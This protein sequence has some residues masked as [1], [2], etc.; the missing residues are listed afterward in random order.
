MCS[1]CT[2]M[3]VLVFTLT[4]SAQR[5]GGGMGGGRVAGP[6]NQSGA[7][8][9]RAGAPAPF[10]GNRGIYLS[11]QS[12]S[13]PIPCPLLWQGWCHSAPP[14]WRA[15]VFRAPYPRVVVWNGW[16]ALGGYGFNSVADSGYPV[17]PYWPDEYAQ[18]FNVP[19]A[20]PIPIDAPSAMSADMAPERVEKSASDNSALPVYQGPASQPDTSEDHPPLVALKNRWAYTV[21]KYWVQGKTFHFITTQG[22]HMQ[23]PVALVERVYPTT[24]RSHRIEPKPAPKN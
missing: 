5:H 10:G 21:L 17:E 22:D 18:S 19:V 11:W 1:S 15:G 7:F 24:D 14:F 3:L 8:P 4:A 23:V 6:P 16:P 2:A 13:D 9:P 20:P 12:G